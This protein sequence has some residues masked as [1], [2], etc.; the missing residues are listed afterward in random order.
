MGARHHRDRFAAYD[1]AA[2]LLTSAAKAFERAGRFMHAVD[3]WL[4]VADAVSAQGDTPRSSMPSDGRAN[5]ASRAASSRLW[6]AGCDDVPADAPPSAA[7][8][9]LSPREQEIA[10]LVA[11]G[12]TNREIVAE[13]F[14]SE[15]TV[16]NQ[17][18]N[19]FANSA[20]SRRPSSPGSSSAA[21]GHLRN[22]R[23]N[24]TSPRYVRTIQLPG[25]DLYRRSGDVSTH[26]DEPNRTTTPALSEVRSSRTSNDDGTGSLRSAGS[27]VARGAASR[28]RT[29][30][31]SCRARRHRDHRRSVRGRR[32]SP[33]ERTGSGRRRASVGFTTRGTQC[34]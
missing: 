11:A 5:L 17:L 1:E 30:G 16:R 8:R 21:A 6:P 29:S 18:V 14:V 26:E 19:V 25:T 34:P 10:Q 15:H 23:D 20:C 33:S 3:S 24:A 27:H 9:S 13:L 28:V 7:L 32:W 12:K 4:D 22:D 31:S 2:A